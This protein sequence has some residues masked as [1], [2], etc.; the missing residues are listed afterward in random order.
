MAKK[1]IVKE[2]I[3]DLT[4]PAIQDEQTLPSAGLGDVVKSITSALG[5]ET[6]T[7]C[8]ERRKQLNKMFPWLNAKEMETLKGEDEALMI[9]I[10]KTPS[11]V[12][13]DDVDALFKLYNRI[14]TPQRPIKRCQ[15]PGLLRTVVERLELLMTQD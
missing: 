10:R 14:Y 13:N 15:C 2:E 8:E 3:V 1:K 6:C 12:Q 9:R 4:A 7:K 5:I 11:A